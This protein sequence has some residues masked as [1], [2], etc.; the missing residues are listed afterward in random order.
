MPYNKEYYLKNKVKI[1]KKG[2]L[3]RKL[4]QEKERARV[5]K[6][7]HAHRKERALYKKSHREEINANARRIYKT[8]IKNNPQYQIRKN[9]HTR[10]YVAIKNNYIK[11]DIHNLGCNLKEF[12]I[13]IESK[14][15]P[16]MKW[17]NYGKKWHIDHIKPLNSFDLTNRKQLLECC[18]FTNT[19]PLWK[20]ENFTKWIKVI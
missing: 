20:E 2:K 13:Y 9:I 5:L 8:K 17:S 1:L 12:K 15:N 6:Y 4:N 14:F 18:H 3:Y 7:A 11:S 10:L 19:Q 16:G